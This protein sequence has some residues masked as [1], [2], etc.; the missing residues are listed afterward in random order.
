MKIDRM[1]DGEAADGAGIDRVALNVNGSSCAAAA[2]NDNRKQPKISDC[3]AGKCNNYVTKMRAGKAVPVLYSR[4]SHYQVGYDVISSGHSFFCFP[5]ATW[6][7]KCLSCT[8]SRPYAWVGLKPTKKSPEGEVVG[9][10]MLFSQATSL[11]TGPTTSIASPNAAGRHMSPGTVTG[12]FLFSHPAGSGLRRPGGVRKL[13]LDVGT[14]GWSS[15]PI[16]CKGKS[17]KLQQKWVRPFKGYTFGSLITSFI[18]GSEKLLDLERRADSASAR[19]PPRWRTCPA[20]R[21][22]ISELHGVADSAGVPFRKHVARTTRYNIVDHRKALEH[23][24]VHKECLMVKAFLLGVV[25]LIHYARTVRS[26]CFIWTTLWRPSMTKLASSPS[27]SWLYFYRCSETRSRPSGSHGRRFQ[28][29]SQPLVYF[30]CTHCAKRG[31]TQPGARE[32]RF[33]SL[34][35][36]G[37]LPGYTMGHTAAGM[38]FSINTLS[39]RRL[40]SGPHTCTEPSI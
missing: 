22:S 7:V 39:P 13:R 29:N 4:G 19:T 38:V 14:L 20:A 32:E 16:Q 40:C 35:Y 34:C 18:A 1:S 9:S 36:A 28:R 25:Y 5:L 11:A 17:S 8:P 3:T 30:V 2:C 26:S 37:Q 21:R 10:A 27:C 23:L 6:R 15:N 31:R 33:T 24:T 12:R